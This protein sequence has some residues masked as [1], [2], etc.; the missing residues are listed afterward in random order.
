MK[1][2][3]QLSQVKRNKAQEFCNLQSGF[4]MRVHFRSFSGVIQ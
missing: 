2:Q 4:S 3:E 1:E